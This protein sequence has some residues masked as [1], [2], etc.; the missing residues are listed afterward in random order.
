MTPLP[1]NRRNLL[2]PIVNAMTVDVED[3]VH[4]SAFAGHIDRRDWDILP[5][6]VERNTDAV[7]DLLGASGANATFFT[8]G[9]VAERYPGLIQRIVDGGGK[10]ILRSE[11]VGNVQD[12]RVG[13]E[14]DSSGEVA[15]AR[16]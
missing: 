12:S 4:V 9:W 15:M 6:R 14:G 16:E 7:L 5:S 1:A 11:P 3:Y 2:P 8:L 10:R 13:P